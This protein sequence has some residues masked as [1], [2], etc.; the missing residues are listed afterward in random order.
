MHYLEHFILQIKLWY[1]GSI[2]SDY[3]KKECSE[4]ILMKG[5][6]ERIFPLPGSLSL[7][8]I[9]TTECNNTQYNNSIASLNQNLNIVILFIYISN[10]PQLITGTSFINMFSN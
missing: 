4:A 6:T 10:L 7:V 5:K 2:S 3:M 1:Q 9:I 8:G